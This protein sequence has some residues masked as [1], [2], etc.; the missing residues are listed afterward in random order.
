MKNRIVYGILGI[1]ATAL[2]LSIGATFAH[3][4]STGPI[5]TPQLNTLIFP[6][7]VSGFYPTI[8]PAVTKGCTLAG[9]SIV[10]SPGS[11]ATGTSGWTIS[12][13]TGGCTKASILDQRVTPGQWYTWNGSAYT[14]VASPSGNV[15]SGT[16]GQIAQYPA[17][18]TT[19]QGATASGDATIAPGGA[20]SV[21]KIHGVAVTGTPTAG[22]VP[23]AVNAVSA[24]WQTPTGG[25]GTNLK[26]ATELWGMGDSYIFGVGATQPSVTGIFGLLARDTPAV[27]FN[28]DAQ[29]GTLSN[30]ISLQVTRTFLPNPTQSA[31]TLTDG[32]ANDGTN[33]T[34]GGVSPSPC[35]TNFKNSMMAQEAWLTIP[36]QFRQFASTATQVGPWAPTGGIVGISPIYVSTGTPMQVST[37]GSTLT[38]AIPSSASPVVGLTYEQVNGQMGTFTVSVD[39]VLKTDNCSTTTAFSSGPCTTFPA[40][41]IGVVRQEFTVTPGTTH[42]VVITTTNA[43]LLQILSVDWVPPAGTA[44]ENVAFVAGVN[45]TFANSVI[46]D[47]AS[48]AVVTQLAADGLPVYFVDLQHGTPGMN[49]TTDIS[50]LATSTCPFSTLSQHPNDCGYANF[51][52]TLQNTEIAA[53]YIFSQLGSGGKATYL[54]GQIAVPLK[55]TT[56]A[57]TLASGYQQFCTVGQIGGCGVVYFTN[58]S[59]NVW[60]AG[61][62]Q[63]ASG[64]QPWSGNFNSITS[65]G[66]G[67]F[68][69]FYQYNG[70]GNTA[71]GNFT[72]RWCEDYSTGNTFQLGTMTANGVSTPTASV[73]AATTTGDVTKFDNAT[74]HLAD[75]GVPVTSLA[76]VAISNS[77][78]ARQQ[79][80]GID[81]TQNSSVSTFV[82]ATSSVNNVCPTWAMGSTYWT[83]S[84]SSAD[85]WTW[86]CTLGTGA[87][88]TSTLSLQHTG[89]TGLAL[90]QFPMIGT[91]SN[92]SSSASPA[93]CA[94][95]PSG[96]FVI[97]ATATSVVVNTTAV[98]ANSQI[99]V[100]EDESLGTKLGVTC[101]TGIIANPPAITARSPGTSFS[102]GITTP[103]T[104][105][106]VCF[107]YTVIN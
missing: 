26:P 37:S 2:L 39:G 92:C 33:D 24:T 11:P 21:N 75:S 76:S 81:T 62:T 102:V 65:F 55:T 89:G 73:L 13:V 8:Q 29:V 83:G 85:K 41:I 7:Q 22:Q 50:T 42:T 86:I 103:L 97:A 10:I 105:N 28:N 4:Q 82:A 54:G 25:G 47:T 36:F 32:G 72:A 5:T 23:T 51:L 106:P 53:N 77:W 30:A 14:A 84:A 57:G 87:N 71:G 70:S 88:P 98:T 1:F 59:G 93:V 99:I 107:S 6:G 17:N 3:P 49:N 43:A 90:L 35:V 16:T 34:C 96:S 12:A 95:S 60:G 80:A 68:G 64:G 31:V 9:A 46:Y 38:F 91:T 52:A 56:A 20:V 66:T 94:S 48:K 67:G 101:N 19:V 79:F 100:Q 27:V 78:A 44:N 58:N 74:G 18:G 45:A 40:E 104:V 61:F 15:A 69:C 63:D